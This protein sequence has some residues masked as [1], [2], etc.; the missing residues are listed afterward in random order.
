M[1]FILHKIVVKLSR[2]EDVRILRIETENEAYTEDVEGLQ[3]T[4]RVRMNVTAPKS[5]V[6][7]A[8]DFPRL[9]RYLRL[10]DNRFVLEFDE[11]LQAIRFRFEIVDRNTDRFGVR[12]LHVVNQKL[13]E[14]ARDNP[15]R[16]L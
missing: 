10:A 1:F 4:R 11:K 6:Q 8:D 3:R 14:I 13:F 16:S 9:D 5:V 7:L 15:S 2:L 12:S